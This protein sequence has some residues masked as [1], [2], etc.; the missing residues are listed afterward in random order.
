MNYLLPPHELEFVKL[1]SWPEAC[2]S[3]PCDFKRKLSTEVFSVM[4]TVLSDQGYEFKGE[5]I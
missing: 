1:Y 4:K 2:T 5:M 3:L